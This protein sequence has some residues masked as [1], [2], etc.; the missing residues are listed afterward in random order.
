MRRFVNQGAKLAARKAANTARQTRATPRARGKRAPVQRAAPALTGS[1]SGA[2]TPPPI[3]LAA[4]RASRGPTPSSGAQP[5]LWHSGPP[6]PPPTR[7]TRGPI[8]STGTQPELP[9]PKRPEPPPIWKQKPP[10]IPAKAIPPRPGPPPIPEDAI[11]FHKRPMSA[12][13]K[14]W[15]TRAAIGGG[16]VGGISM[17]RRRD[18]GGPNQNLYR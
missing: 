6:T 4:R 7:V 8:P 5:D 17:M 12:D 14:K 18:R 15:G 13:M 11:P 2:A 3:P 16:A 10:P 1:S 9:F